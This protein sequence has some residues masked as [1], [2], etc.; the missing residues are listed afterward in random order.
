[1]KNQIIENLKREITK[2]NINEKEKKG[3][4]KRGRIC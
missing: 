3:E 2:L 4:K 1:V